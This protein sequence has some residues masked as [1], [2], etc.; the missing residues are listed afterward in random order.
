[1][2]K[3]SASLELLLAKEY[4]QLFETFFSAIDAATTESLYKTLSNY[5]RLAEELFHLFSQ[6]LCIGTRQSIRINPTKSHIYFGAFTLFSE[7]IPPIMCK[8]Q[9]IS[10]KHRQTRCVNNAYAKTERNQLAQV[11]LE[12]SIG[13]NY[14]QQYTSALEVKETLGAIIDATEQKLLVLMN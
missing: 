12:R 8:K 4:H 6:I 1:M 5:P 11:L 9:H 2:Q 13:T 10:F 7:K 3:N 14:M